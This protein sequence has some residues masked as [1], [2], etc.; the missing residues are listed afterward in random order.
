MAVETYAFPSGTVTASIGYTGIA[1]NTARSLLLEYAD[2]ALYAA[3]AG[4]RNRICFHEQQQH[5]ELASGEI[6]LF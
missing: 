1:A 2:K 3:K 4:G 6:E 5:A